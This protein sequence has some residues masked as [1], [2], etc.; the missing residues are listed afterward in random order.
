MDLRNL[1]WHRQKVSRIVNFN[2]GQPDQDFVGD[3]INDSFGRID[4]AINECAGNVRNFLLN[5]VGQ[6]PL[7][8]TVSDTW[9]SGSVTHTLNVDPADIISIYDVTNDA[10]GQPLYT[11]NK[12]Y[13]TLI[14]WKDGRTLQW[15]TAGPGSALTLQITYVMNAGE[16]NE[17]MQ[18]FEFL[19]YA[20]RHVIN[21]GAAV[22]LR[23]MADESA[24]QNWTQ[25]YDTLLEDLEMHLSKGQ[26]METGRPRIQNRRR[27]R[28]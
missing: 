1:A 4:D 21:W 19:P 13:N 12:V 18:E 14:F 5:N 28:M 10:V 3:S 7:E 23:T 11:Q 22:L 20:H 8:R 24:P 16:L 2:D 9:P 15:G 27:R 26:P 17:P 25:H 6:V